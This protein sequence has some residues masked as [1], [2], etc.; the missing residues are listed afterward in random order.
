LNQYNLEEGYL[1]ISDFRKIE[2]LLGENKDSKIEINVSDKKLWM[3]IVR[4]GRVNY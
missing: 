1:I 4:K 3:S 2:N